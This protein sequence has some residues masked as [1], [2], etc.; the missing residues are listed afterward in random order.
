MLENYVGISHHLKLQY[1]IIES[2]SVGS[3]T[4]FTTAKV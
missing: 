3:I 2:I 1:I 4:V